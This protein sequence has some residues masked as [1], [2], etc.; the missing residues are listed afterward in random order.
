MGYLTQAWS[1]MERWQQPLARWQEQQLPCEDKDKQ[2]LRVALGAC[3]EMGE[4]SRCVLKRSQ[5]IR[6]TEHV[7]RMR[8]EEEIGDVIVYLMQLCT[9]LDLDIEA[10]IERAASKVLARQ[11]KKK[12]GEQ[13]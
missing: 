7:W 9:L 12:E 11:W 1:M 4:V 6:A 10:C 3:E 2:A 5:E 8:A 13:P